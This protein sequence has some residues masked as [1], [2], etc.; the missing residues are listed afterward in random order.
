MNK[1]KTDLLLTQH[2][3]AQMHG[4]GGNHDCWTH[5]HQMSLSQLEE[6]DTNDLRVWKSIRTSQGASFSKTFTVAGRRGQVLF[7]FACDR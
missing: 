7:V 5:G 3:E 2:D 1:H 6:R 4:R